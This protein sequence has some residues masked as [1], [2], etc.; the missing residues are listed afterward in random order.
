MMLWSLK[1]LGILAAAI[2]GA[3][4]SVIFLALMLL[5]GAYLAI[6]PQLPSVETLRSPPLQMPLRIYARDGR[7]IAEFAAERREPV[8]IDQVPDL[9]RLAFLAAEDDRFATHV[10]VNP[11]ALLRAARHVATTGER[12][13]GGSTITMQLAR[14]V[15]LTPEKTYTRKFAEMI[16][17]LRIEQHFSKGEI[18]QLYMNQIFLGHR[19]YGVAAAAQVYYGRALQA[20]TLAEMAM[21]AGLPQAPSVANPIT[22]PERALQ[23]RNHVLRRMHDLGYITP[24]AYNAARQEPITAR[25]V[26]PQSEVVGAGYWAE[27]TRLAVLERWGEAALTAGW[28]V[29][30]TLDPEQQAQATQAVRVGLME[31]DRR[32]SYRGAEVRFALPDAVPGT[33]PTDSAAARALIRALAN[34]PRQIGGL[35][36]GIVTEVSPHQARVFAEDGRTLTLDA[37]AAAW[38]LPQGHPPD[39]TRILARGHL[40]RLEIDAQQAISLAQIPAA[41]AALVALDPHSGAIQAL[42]GGFDFH[43]SQFNRATQARRQPGSAFKPFI[44]AL[45]LQAG[46]SPA[47]IIDDAPISV[48]DPSLGRDWQPRNFTGQFYGP[49]RLRVAL[50]HS[51]NLSAIHLLDQLGLDTAHAALSDLGF[52]RDQH[53]RG[54]SLALGSGSVTPLE[55]AAGYALFA[56]GG[57]RIE[58]WFIEFIEDPNGQRVWTA[59]PRA[60]P[61]LEPAVAYQITSMLQ[62][63]ITQGTGQRARSLQR[64]DL[65]GKTGT[66]NARRDT[67]FSGYNPELVATVWVGFDD[68]R[69]LGNRE[70]GSSSALPIWMHFM[71]QALQGQAD[72]PW[73]VPEDLTLTTLDADTGGLANLWTLNPLQE[74]LTP[75]QR[76][77]L[78]AQATPLRQP[79]PHEWTPIHIF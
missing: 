63:V 72:R 33:V 13:Q 21:L 30:T 49:N 45:A 18:L 36:A 14:G 67:W 40:I 69:S 23:R 56:N 38:A 65:A 50:T 1:V 2:L 62:D 68:N 54:L 34:Y 55:L 4:V 10:G 32:H 39:L 46:Y 15:F 61:V 77:Q 28:R 37:S 6:A 20:L 64:D 42:V 16:L 75:S 27:M 9:L 44:Y 57:R 12:T 51:R 58:P 19:A 31:Y 43:H 11:A 47:S 5:L 70:T 59:A 8:T 25:L 22:N 29:Y 76:E 24:E 7:F 26:T 35:Q 79:E 53:P 3:A 52:A 41:N 78:E 74:Y 71:R 60:E 48:P 73:N 17:A 66:T